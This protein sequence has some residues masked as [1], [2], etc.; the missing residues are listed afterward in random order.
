MME[1]QL[2]RLLQENH[3]DISRLVLYLRRNSVKNR[4]RQKFEDHTVTFEPIGLE[5]NQFDFRN[6]RGRIRL[7]TKF[8]HIIRKSTKS[9]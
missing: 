6:L 4:A 7:D 9:I 5:Q 1:I 3:T 8:G 2:W